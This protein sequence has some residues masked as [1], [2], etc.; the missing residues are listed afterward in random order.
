[1]ILL[2]FSD[3]SDSIETL[4]D[5]ISDDFVEKLI[6]TLGHEQNTPLNAVINLSA[7]LILDQLP[8]DQDLKSGIMR[9]HSFENEKVFAIKFDGQTIKTPLMKQ[10]VSIWS[11]GKQMKLHSES[12]RFVHLCKSNDFKFKM[13]RIDEA[14]SNEDLADGALDANWSLGDKILR[15]LMVFERTFVSKQVK[16]YFKED[17]SLKTTFD[18]GYPFIDWRVYES[19]LFH[20]ITNA[21]KFSRRGG[22]II[23]KLSLRKA[24]I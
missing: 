9:L 23:I 11:S 13:R 21:L 15:F 3:V 8:Q 19:I 1:M 20:I 18:D 10:L 5:H 16:V 12:Q 2:H 7:N 22:K 6:R 24:S 14:L 4:I 17:Q